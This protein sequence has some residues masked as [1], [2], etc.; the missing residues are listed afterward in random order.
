[1]YGKSFINIP[2]APMTRNI[3]AHLTMT[4]KI[5][6]LEAQNLYK[7]RAL[8]RRI[9]DIR[10]ETGLKVLDKWKVDVTGQRYKVYYLDGAQ[11]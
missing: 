6:N 3:F 9:K 4:G 8:P 11:V 1:M 5:T 7:C 2:S 10:E